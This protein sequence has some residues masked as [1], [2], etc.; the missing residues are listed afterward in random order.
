VPVGVVVAE[1]T[2]NVEDP[3]V[4]IEEGENEAVTPDGNPLMLK[5]IVPTNPACGAAETV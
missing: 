2:V 3:D 5:L 1:F 4:T